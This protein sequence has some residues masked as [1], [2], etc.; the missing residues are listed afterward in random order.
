ME[1]DNDDLPGCLATLPRELHYIVPFALRYRLVGESEVF[2]AIDRLTDDE[3]TELFELAA[4]VRANEDYQKAVQ[5][6]ICCDKKAPSPESTWLYY[7][8][9]LLDY[10]DARFD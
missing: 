9:G 1:F 5:F 6:T 3:K 10:I 8:F 4:F 7:L 2:E